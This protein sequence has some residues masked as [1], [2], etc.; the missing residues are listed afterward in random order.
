MEKELSQGGQT[1]FSHSPSSLLPFLSPQLLTAAL[2]G[3]GKDLGGCRDCLSSGLPVTPFLPLLCNHYALHPL[4]HRERKTEGCSSRPMGLGLDQIC[5]SLP[6]RTYQENKIF[7]SKT[8]KKLFPN[9]T[10][11]AKANWRV[12]CD[13]HCG[14]CCGHSRF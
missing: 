13:S 4:A 7:A 11:F 6:D 14:I 5:A 12:R 3:E 8:S 9:P 10:A 2:P 1:S